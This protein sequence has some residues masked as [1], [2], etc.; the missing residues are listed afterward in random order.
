MNDMNIDF[1]LSQ[2]ESDQRDRHPPE[3][4]LEDSGFTLNET[5]L[6]RSGYDTQACTDTIDPTDSQNDILGPDSVTPIHSQLANAPLLTYFERLSRYPLMTAREEKDSF[7]RL[8][9]HLNQLIE[10]THSAVNRLG[11]ASVEKSLECVTKDNH[12]RVLQLSARLIDTPS[13][14]HSD[15]EAMIFH[16]QK[17]TALRDALVNANLRLVVFISKRYLT[18]LNSMSDLIQE[19]NTGL[20]RAI[21]KYD[22]QKG[23]RFS[24]Y[25]Y[26]W[27]QQRIFRYASDHWRLIRLPSNVSDGLRQWKTLDPELL[28]E[29]ETR[30]TDKKSRRSAKGRYSQ[31]EPEKLQQK[32]GNGFI[33][34]LQYPLSL[35]SKRSS[36]SD[37]SLEETLI[38]QQPDTATVIEKQ[39]T[40]AFIHKTLDTLTAREKTIICMRYGIKMS[41]SYTFREISQQLNI[42]IERVRQLE[43]EILKKLRTLSDQTTADNE[44]AIDK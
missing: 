34:Q 24:T 11:A 22:W 19:G 27:I 5:C 13:L 6:T 21:E 8:H 37:S 35:S 3:R 20:L 31:D 16:F 29:T 44:D 23:N 15:R 39:D 26:W 28:P 17:A 7:A 12:A 33:N 1:L 14:T 25:A 30:I 41:D 38:S 18:R 32:F 2:S 10:Q 40:A 36:D 9:Y 43:R 4:V 42:S